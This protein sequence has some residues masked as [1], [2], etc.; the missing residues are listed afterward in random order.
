MTVALTPTISLMTDQC[1]KLKQNGKPATFL[2]SSQSE[3]NIDI[4]IKDGCFRVVLSHQRDFLMRA[5]MF[6]KLLQ[7]GVIGLLAID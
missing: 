4:K 3:R 1:L 2:G 7:G 6:S 5:V